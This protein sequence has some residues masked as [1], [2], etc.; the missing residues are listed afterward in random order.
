MRLEKLCNKRNN[1]A[2]YIASSAQCFVP[3][4]LKGKS[5]PSQGQELFLAQSLLTWVL[6]T[7][8]RCQSLRF[9]PGHL[10][11]YILI[12]LRESLKTNVSEQGEMS[13]TEV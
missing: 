1:F 8:R 3:L 5:N 2:G 9:C 11:N 7:R 6:M 12:A 13:E 10:N 4:I